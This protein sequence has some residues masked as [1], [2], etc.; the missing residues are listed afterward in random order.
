MKR[1]L[2]LVCTL[3]IT[4]SAAAQDPEY[5]A[6][7]T[8]PS[9]KKGDLNKFRSWVTDRIKAAQLYGDG[10]VKISFVVERDG[11]VG[12]VTL[13]EGFDTDID[14]K[15][16]KIISQSPKWKPG[17]N[18]NN[19]P[20]SVKYTLP[21]T[22]RNPSGTINIRMAP[23]NS[24]QQQVGRSPYPTANGNGMQSHH[25]LSSRQVGFGR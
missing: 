3:L 21:I 8:P 23:A 24:Y 2:L 12:Q 5:N 22:F 20:V 16:M 25:G 4:L 18:A 6:L 14:M 11:S 7:T 9:F 15:V 17:I 1:L 19:E 10:M 13:V